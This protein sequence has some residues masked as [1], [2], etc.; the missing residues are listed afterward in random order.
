MP[1]RE[2]STWTFEDTEGPN[3]VWT[4]T[5]VGGDLNQA[6]ATMLVVTDGITLT[7]HWECQTGGSMASFDYAGLESEQADVEMVMELQDGSG[8]FLAAADLL[9]LGFTWDFTMQTVFSYTMSAE[10]MSVDAFGTLAMTETHEVVSVDPVTFNGVTVPGVEIVGENERV[11][12][13]NMMGVSQPQYTVESDRMIFGY[14]IGLL[15]DITDSDFGKV[16]LILTSY[17]VP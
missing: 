9:E 11:M 5:E 12:T 8:E 14:G 4:I 10:D 3:A 1:I 16:E 7:Y 15:K 13:I 17:Y 6:E 2:G